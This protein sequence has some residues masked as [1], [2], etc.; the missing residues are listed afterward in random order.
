M[1]PTDYIKNVLITEARDMTPL[2]ERF[3]QI[4]TIRLLH[5]AIGLASELS[6]IR[7]M[8]QGGD[9]DVVNLKE[10][11][12]DL[13][14]Y[15]GVMVDELK[16]DPDMIFAESIKLEDV[17]EH[18]IVPELHIAIDE[19]TIAIGKAIDILK[20]NVMYGKDLNVKEIENQLMELDSWICHALALYNI[21]PGEARSTNIEK[22]RLRYGQ[23]FTEA[24]AN[25]RNLEAERKILSK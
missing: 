8:A 16:S 18:D 6:E 11:M 3:S 23:K 14:W 22:L 4:R 15:M 10:E 13:F 20:K 24:A 1:K 12:G 17:Y 5:G 9:I 7:E 25:E 21:L 19:M 2:Q